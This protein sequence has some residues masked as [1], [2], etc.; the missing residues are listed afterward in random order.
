MVATSKAPCIR[1]RAETRRDG[2]VFPYMRNHD[3][4]FVVKPFIPLGFSFLG[5]PVSLWVQTREL[6]CKDI[7]GQHFFAF[8][9]NAEEN[10]LDEINLKLETRE[11]GRVTMYV[12]NPA[13][14]FSTDPFITLELDFH[15]IPV[16]LRVKGEQLIF[17]KVENQ[18]KSRLLEFDIVLAS[19]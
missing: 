2:S 1:L 11:D 14:D 13:G 9:I 18:Q 17:Y 12:R 5:S 15:G 16:V 6:I 7:N 4:D 3:D 19:D 10:H 8:G